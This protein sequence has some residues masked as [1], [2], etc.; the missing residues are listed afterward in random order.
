MRAN[1]YSALCA[2]GAGTSSVGAPVT[3]IRA[4]AFARGA[5][6]GLFSAG[7]LAA[8][9]GF[10]VGRGAPRRCGGAVV[11]EGEIFSDAVTSVSVVRLCRR[12][13]RLPRRRLGLI[14]GAPSAP[15][16][17]ERGCAITASAS[18][19][20]CRPPRLLLGR[21]G[22]VPAPSSPFEPELNDRLGA[23]GDRCRSESVGETDPLGN[24]AS[25][26]GS[27]VARAIYRHC[28]AAIT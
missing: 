9:S 2:N 22:G 6:A 26:A 21:R 27:A 25:A 16:V 14:S 4:R 10:S 20:R 1:S 11:S 3:G 8:C 15:V 19:P 23:N 7:G 5:R 12:P 13:P 24:R 28:T 17:S 18:G